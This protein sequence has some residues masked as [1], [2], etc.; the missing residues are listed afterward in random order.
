[1]QTTPVM[2]RVNSSV[3]VCGAVQPAGRKAPIQRRHVGGGRSDDERNLEAH[4]RQRHHADD[5]PDRSRGGTHRQRVFGAV[6]QITHDLPDA[7]PVAGVQQPHQDA[8]RNAPERRHIGRVARQQ[9]ADQDDQRNDRRPVPAE[10]RFQIRHFIRAQSAQTGTL[11]LEM[12]LHQHAE[13][14]HEGRDDG[15]QDDR[16]IGQP[17]KL[18]HQEGRG[19]HDRRRD[20]PARRSRRLDSG[21]EMRLVAEPDHRRDGQRSDR[22]RIGDRRPGN[23]AEQRRPEDR[24]LGRPSGEAPR[25]PGGAIQ[26]KLTQ[27]DTGGEDAEQ[28]EVEDIRRHHAQRDPVNALRR[29]VKVIDKLRKAGAGMDQDTRHRRSPDRIAHED[30]C[31]DRQRPADGTPGRLQ[32]HEDQNPAEHHVSRGRIADAERQIVKRDQRNMQDRHHGADS[33]RPVQQRNAERA[34]QRRSSPAGRSRA[35]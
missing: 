1:M 33:Q 15:R 12:H 19:P 14:M 4:P 31:D 8:Q 6:T 11:R 9:N 22:H 34:Q 24:H 28:H 27:P 23:H 20:L 30:Q 7:H 26:E 21:G 29:Q 18:D 25:D 17:Q 13:E 35:W 2:I 32:Q 5:D 3:S 16:R 10:R